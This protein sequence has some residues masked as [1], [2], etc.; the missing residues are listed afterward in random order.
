MSSKKAKKE[1]KEAKKNE[2]KEERLQRLAK[3]TQFQLIKPFGPFFGMFDMPDEIVQALIKKSDEILEDRNRVDWGKNLVG[4]ISEEPWISNED[5]DEIGALK[6]LEG[7]LHNYV[8]NSLVADGVELE[9]LECNL[10]HA[11]I[12]SQYE[13]EYNPVHFHTYCD[14]SS[15][16]YLKVP[17]FDDRSKTGNLPDYKHQRDGMIEFIYKTACPTGLEKGSL[18]FNPEPGKLV[19]FPS[20]LLHTVYPFKGDGERRSI[21]FNSHWQA[22]LKNGKLF[23]KSFR[24]K[25]DQKHEEYQKTLTSK[26]K[27]SGFAKRKQ[28]SP[29]SGASEKENK[30]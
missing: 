6:Y 4:Q 18:S 14:L 28:G 9:A 15:V 2:T 16:L 7:M 26:G 3:E 23:D 25:S 17:S 1:R 19:V 22:K 29:D 5:L 11:W 12:V 8:W 20:N 10:D 21:A 24:M 27:E 13:N 30:I